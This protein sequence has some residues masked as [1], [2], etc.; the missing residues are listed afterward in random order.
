MPCRRLRL[1]RRRRQCECNKTRSRE[2]S[3]PRFDDANVARQSDDDWRVGASLWAAAAATAQAHLSTLSAIDRAR[4]GHGAALI[5]PRLQLE[6]VTRRRRRPHRSN[7]RRARKI[8]A[9]RAQISSRTSCIDR[10]NSCRK[11][12]RST[13]SLARVCVQ[14]SLTRFPRMARPARARYCC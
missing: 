11:L 8:C 4:P 9:Q 1:R 14:E 7:L 10:S 5:W 12:A 6:R 3:A 2:T 13:R